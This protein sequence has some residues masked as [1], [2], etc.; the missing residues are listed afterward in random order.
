MRFRVFQY[1]LP[2]VGELPDL[3]AFLASQRVATV[4]HHVVAHGQGGML[5]FVVEVAGGPAGRAAP[6]GHGKVDYRETLSPAQFELF[7]R[8]RAARKAW[9]DSEGLP[10]YALFTNAQLAQMAAGSCATAADLA[11]IEGVGPARS[12]KYAERLL[13]ILKPLPAPADAAAG[14]ALPAVAAP[15]GR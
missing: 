14:S 11:R 15:E 9:A 2:T 5:V 7:T 4:D 8:L 10:V 13:A 1:P 12:E 3:N 6:T